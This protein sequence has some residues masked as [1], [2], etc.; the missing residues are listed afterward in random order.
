MALKQLQPETTRQASATSK[1]KEQL[2]MTPHKRK[3]TRQALAAL[4]LFLL[5]LV[6]LS[7]CAKSEGE[8]PQRTPVKL[9]LDFYPNPDHAGIYTGLATGAFEQAGLDLEVET[10]SDPAAP[11]KQVAA[12]RTDLA[13]S[14]QPELLLAR[15]QGLDV[16]AVAA[17]VNR[18]LTSMIWLQK[19]K[20]KEVAD[21]KGKT[22][23]TAGIPYQDAFLD[24]ILTGA[25][26]PAD[27]VKRVNVG[28]GLQP[29][30]LSGRAQ[31]VLGAFRNIEGV[32][33]QR[34]GKKPVIN[35]VDKLG[36]PRYDELILVARE[37][38]LED[39]AEKIRLFLAALERATAAAI[40][41][42][43]GATDA[44]LAANDALE[45]ELT[46]AWVDAT[47]PLLDF[48]DETFGR[49]DPSRW[50]SFIAW[51]RDNGLINALPSAGEA[52][53]NSLL[54]SGPPKNS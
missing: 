17:I 13:I 22:V 23:A 20:I 36:I 10:P 48:G 21:L 7:A 53:T 43:A 45:P 3:T 28:L 16:K 19:S 41:D 25:G 51:M 18:P 9:T 37:S 33:L 31:A 54:P 47:L 46:R 42:P 6:A 39:N 44:V 12:G 49:M 14:Y 38:T 4:G 32:E 11:I 5:A 34:R 40:A 24:S 27:S 2:S 29:A 8:A 15:D 1:T 35:P 52:M 26:I 50:T 30:I